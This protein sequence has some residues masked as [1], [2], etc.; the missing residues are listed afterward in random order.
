MTRIVLAIVL[1]LGV[2]ACG[3][4]D[5]GAAAGGGTVDVSMTEYAFDPAP[6]A[7]GDGG[8]LHVT[9]DGAEVHNLTIR[10]LGKGIEL[11]P[12]HEGTLHLDGLQAGTY[13]VICDITGHADKGM[14]TQITLG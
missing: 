5:G 1:A 9:N 2:A 13:E 11:Q 3:G 14:K 10:K 12:G 4:D 6:I 7:V 8:E